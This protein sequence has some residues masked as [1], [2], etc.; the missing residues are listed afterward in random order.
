M[1]ERGR[2]PVRD[3]VMALAGVVGP[4]GG[5][6]ADLLIRCDLVEQPGQHGRITH[7]AAGDL[8]SADFVCF[9]VDPEMDLAP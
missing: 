9:L 8:D 7:V 2:A 5:Y 3:G 6:G 4:I 1:P